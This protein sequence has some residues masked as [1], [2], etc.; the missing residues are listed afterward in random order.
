MSSQTG[1]QGSEVPRLPGMVVRPVERRVYEVQIGPAHPGSGHMRIF[2]E[3]DG[4]VMTR[5]DPDIGFVHRTMEKLAEGRDWIKNIPL[6]ERMAILDA[7]NITLPY[8]EAVE[9]LLDLD[10]P[11]R[12]KYLRVLLCE[13]NRIASHL[14]GFGIFGV[15]LGHSTLYMWAFGDREVF[16]QLAEDLT[17]ARLTHSYPV[18]GGVRRDIPDDFPQ[19][20]RKATRYM[21]GRLDEYAK[22]F[23]NNPNIRSRLEGVGVLSKNRAAELG[24]VGPNARASGIKYDVRLVE[25]YEAYDSL[26]SRY[27]YSRRGTR[28]R[29]PGRGLRR[30]SR[31]ST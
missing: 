8:V 28:W 26:T 31:A 1:V 13:I 11:E 5:V 27:R 14:Y 24:V 7:C 6:F 4:D 3:V 20:A 9:R 29:G 23:L 15:F 21:R 2:V 19:N 16:V 10:P 25:P 18:F 30:S 17:G 22:I 12:A